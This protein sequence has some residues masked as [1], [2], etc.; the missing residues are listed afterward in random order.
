MFDFEQLLKGYTKEDEFIARDT[1]LINL[2][3]RKGIITKEEVEDA[4]K[5]LEEVI[6]EVHDLRVEDTKR[7]ADEAEARLK[8]YYANENNKM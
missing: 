3:I 8:E 1:L 5:G 2:L 6:K 7:K 4:F